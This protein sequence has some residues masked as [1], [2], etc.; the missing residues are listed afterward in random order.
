MLGSN[1]S[2]AF[3]IPANENVRITNHSPR[4]ARP[5]SLEGMK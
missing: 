1:H 4:H 3:D 2:I 5:V